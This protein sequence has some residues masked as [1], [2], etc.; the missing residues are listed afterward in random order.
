VSRPNFKIGLTYFGH[1]LIRKMFGVTDVSAA[2]KPEPFIMKPTVQ[3]KLDKQL[4]LDG[5]YN[6]EEVHYKLKCSTSVPMC[7]IFANR[8]VPHRILGY[9]SVPMCT[10]RVPV[11]NVDC[12]VVPKIIS[13]K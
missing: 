2:Q 11:S 5:T 7:T 12:R 13:V 3:S 1:V 4:S 9:T 10:I 6:K 8:C